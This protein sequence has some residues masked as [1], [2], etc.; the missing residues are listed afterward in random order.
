MN[1]FIVST[2]AGKLL[3]SR[4]HTHTAR[5]RGIRFCRNLKSIC[6]HKYLCRWSRHVC[7]LLQK[8]IFARRSYCWIKLLSIQICEWM[9][10]VRYIRHTQIALAFSTGWMLCVHCWRYEQ[11]AHEYVVAVHWC[12]LAVVHVSIHVRRKVFASSLL[13]FLDSYLAWIISMQEISYK[14]KVH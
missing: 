3:T 14:V 10:S 8:W 2:G 6:L 11:Q 5:L 4:T 1:T 7:I 12:L 13:L 9:L